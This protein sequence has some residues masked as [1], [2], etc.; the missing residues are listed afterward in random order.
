V[1]GSQPASEGALEASD[2]DRIVEDTKAFHVGAHSRTDPETHLTY[3]I[4]IAMQSDLST[5]N[6]DQF[7]LSAQVPSGSLPYHLGTGLR[8]SGRCDMLLHSRF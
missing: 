1:A 6:C 5:S 7:H 8:T 3:C 2:V 4:Q